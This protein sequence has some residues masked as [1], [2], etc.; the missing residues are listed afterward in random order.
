MYCADMQ[1]VPVLGDTNLVILDVCV[2]FNKI[3]LSANHTNII[4]K[5]YQQMILM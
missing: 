5:N 1:A 2:C 4:D 3:L